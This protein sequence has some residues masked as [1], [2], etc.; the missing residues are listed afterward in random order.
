MRRTWFAAFNEPMKGQS[1][2]TSD[3]QAIRDLMD[4]W[5]QA[6]AEGDLPRV[7]DLMADDVVFLAPGR[8]P[9]RGKAEFAARAAGTPHIESRQEVKEI[10]VTGEWAYCWTE[11]FVAMTPPEGGPPAR[12]SGH[13]LSVMRKQPNGKW[14]LA[15]DANMLAPVPAQ[16]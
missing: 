12:R 6:T 15:R 10:V 13:T 3:E 9:M 16:A 7:L 8:P 5:R 11:L 4:T 14:V 1:V 2:M